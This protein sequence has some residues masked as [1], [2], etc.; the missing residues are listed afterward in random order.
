LNLNRR[1]SK[2]NSRVR[3]VRLI[4]NMTVGELAYKANIDRVHLEKIES[5]SAPCTE[6]N[7]RRIAEL[8]GM[9]CEWESFVTRPV[10]YA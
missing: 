1:R 9:P 7:A 6:L 3:Y 5:G 4:N 10:Q 8:F 2:K